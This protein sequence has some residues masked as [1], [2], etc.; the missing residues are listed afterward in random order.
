[1]PNATITPTPYQTALDGNGNPLS[2]A[3]IYTYA[4]GTTTP[5]TTYTDSTGS[6]ANTNPIV[7]DS[8][9]RWV[10][11]LEPGQSYKF[12]VK[13]SAGVTVN[14]Q[15]NVLGTYATNASTVTV[16]GVT[17]QTLNVYDI[18][19]LRVTTPGTPGRWVLASNGAANTSTIPI[20]GVALNNTTPGGITGTAAITVALSNYTITTTG[21]TAGAM[22]YINA[23]GGWTSTAPSTNVRV[24]G[25]ALSSTQLLFNPKPAT[26]TLGLSGQLNVGNQAATGTIGS[27]VITTDGAGVNKIE[28]GTNLTAATAAPLA[29]TNMGAGTEWM[30]ITSAGKVGI[31]TN[32]PLKNL[33]V[34]GGDA[35][36]L[37]VTTDGSDHGYIDAVDTS[38]GATAR[39]LLFQPTGGYTTLGT[40]TVPSYQLQVEGTTSSGAGTPQCP[41]SIRH[42]GATSGKYWG[43]GPASSN[44]F[45]VFNQSAT[46]MYMVDGATAW[47]ASSDERLKDIIEPITDAVQKVGTLRS[48]IGKFKTD[49]DTTRRAFLIAQDVQSVLPEAVTV[50]DNGYLGVAY[51]DVIPLLVAAIKELKARVEALE[52]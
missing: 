49:D 7:A 32:A 36:S 45:V 39:K 30:R 48:V 43:I 18:V 5:A 15:D 33:S 46:G 44:N 19:C 25:Q 42:T 28:S 20:I 16:T 47:T 50:D 11:Y 52:A 2:G 31:G 17:D 21:L 41:M 8:A 26:N 3:L 14:T 51:T 38:T 1:M 12:V 37:N 27:L 6:V 10:A 22:Y 4:A 40:S 23:A 9:G 35:S 29:F 24:I 13:T 34:C